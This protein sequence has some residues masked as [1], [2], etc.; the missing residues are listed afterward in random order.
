MNETGV[1]VAGSVVSVIVFTG[2]FFYAMLTFGRWA[3]R[4]EAKTTPPKT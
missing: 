2:I 3:D 4:G 1:F